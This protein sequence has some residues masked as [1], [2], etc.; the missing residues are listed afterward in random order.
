MK[1]D[2]TRVLTNLDGKDILVDKHPLQMKAV[3][4]NALLMEYPD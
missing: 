1:V 4:V 2:V 3:F